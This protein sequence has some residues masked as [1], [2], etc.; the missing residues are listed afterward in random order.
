MTDAGGSDGRKLFNGRWWQWDGDKWL[1][2]PEPPTADGAGQ[3][4]SSPAPP[5]SGDPPRSELMRGM[6]GPATPPAT[7]T[8][9]PGVAPVTPDGPWDGDEYDPEYLVLLE[10]ARRDVAARQAGGS[11]QTASASSAQP[12]ASQNSKTGCGTLVALAIVIL[13]IVGACSQ[14]STPSPGTDQK[15]TSY[16]GT[17]H[18]DSNGNPVADDCHAW[19]VSTSN[20]LSSSD[21]VETGEALCEGYGWSASGGVVTGPR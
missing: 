13:V 19:A 4:E 1:L 21:R 9:E 17:Y 11:A 6:D 12:P 20:H 14:S 8:P 16:T 15:S 10:Q 2:E 3:A 18:N 7:S 5:T